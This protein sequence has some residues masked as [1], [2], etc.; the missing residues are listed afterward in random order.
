MC[1]I[2]HYKYVCTVCIENMIESTQLEIDV[3][4]VPAAKIILLNSIVIQ[5]TPEK[6]D[7]YLIDPTETL[8][9]IVLLT[10]PTTTLTALPHLTLF[11]S[12]LVSDHLLHFIS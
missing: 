7:E 1:R 6:D 5:N 10:A 11:G 4:S 9:P 2:H 12:S 3:K 8:S